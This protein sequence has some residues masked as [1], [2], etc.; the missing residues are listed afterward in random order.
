[1]YVVTGPKVKN[2]RLQKLKYTFGFKATK[3]IFQ[4]FLHS[5]QMHIET[6]S[7]NKLQTNTEEI[8]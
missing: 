5:R 2:I 3:T 7:F 1:M 4:S 8:R 6:H